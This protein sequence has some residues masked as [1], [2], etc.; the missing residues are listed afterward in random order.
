MMTAT[1]LSQ[2]DQPIGGSGAAPLSKASAKLAM[3]ASNTASMTCTRR[4]F[5]SNILLA[6][7][8][9]HGQLC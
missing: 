2:E 6:H 4:D 1:H 7:L 9:V 5:R 8:V 3:T